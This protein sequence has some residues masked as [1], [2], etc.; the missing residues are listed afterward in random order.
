MGSEGKGK[1]KGKKGKGKDSFT[2]GALA[3]KAKAAAT[4]LAAHAAQAS[5]AKRSAEPPGFPE[6]G[7]GIDSWA[8]VH[9]QHVPPGDETTKWSQSL[10]LANGSTTPCRVQTGVKRGF[11]WP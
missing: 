5:A 11:Q 1:G 6:D 10:R 7:V 9:L 2:K 4:S 8:N 3:P